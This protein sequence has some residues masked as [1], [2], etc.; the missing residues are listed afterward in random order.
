MGWE[1]EPRINMF[2]NQSPNGMGVGAESRGGGSQQLEMPLAGS[3]KFLCRVI[4]I[5]GD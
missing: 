3:A 2:L 4:A 1:G 5:Y